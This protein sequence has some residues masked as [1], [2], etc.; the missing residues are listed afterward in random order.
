MAFAL[1]NLGYRL[2][3]QTRTC[4]PLKSKGA[5]RV[6]VVEIDAFY[7]TRPHSKMMR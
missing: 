2:E 6:W 4:E 5:R 3:L 7:K 1:V